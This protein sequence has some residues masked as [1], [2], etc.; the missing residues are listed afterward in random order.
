[1]GSR[2]GGE[3]EPRK[4]IA[5]QAQDCGT[6]EDGGR[7]RHAAAHDVVGQES[8]SSVHERA[9]ECCLTEG[10]RSGEDQ[11]DAVD[12]DGRRMN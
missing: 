4:N 12:I 3:V 7:R 6:G 9:A 8:I 2:D 5:A 1:M 10:T 11:T